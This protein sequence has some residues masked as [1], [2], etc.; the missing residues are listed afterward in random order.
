MTEILNA[1]R[2]LSDTC[3]REGFGRETLT[4]EL[5]PKL[6]DRVRLDLAETGLFANSVAALPSKPS[7]YGVEIVRKEG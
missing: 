4:I 7:Y 2:N 5:S 3:I 6:Y 1:I